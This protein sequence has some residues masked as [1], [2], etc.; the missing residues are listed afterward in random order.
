MAKIEEKKNGEV[1]QET[2]GWVKIQ[3]D[4]PVY[5]ADRGKGAAVQ[6]L[7]LGLLDMPPSKG[8][9]WRAFVVRLTQPCPA[10]KGKVAITANRGDEILVP[11]TL[12]LLRHLGRAAT[13]PRLMFEVRFKPTG[14][15]ETASGQM[16]EFSIEV[17]EQP[18]ARGGAE[19]LLAMQSGPPALTHG[20]SPMAGE[21]DDI[22]F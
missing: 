18:I 12:Q 2:S 9:A 8:K 6:G 10:R 13:H 11:A 17:N 22:P 20:P 3:T 16:I 19:R 5:T 21:A 14:Q 15:I 1:P 4:R 7:V